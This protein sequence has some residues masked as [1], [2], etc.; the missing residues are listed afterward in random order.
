MGRADRRSRCRYRRRRRPASS[1]ASPGLGPRSRTLG[2][3]LGAPGSWWR[4][5]RGPAR[6]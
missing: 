4:A 5:R 1:R 6:A 3:S 2:G